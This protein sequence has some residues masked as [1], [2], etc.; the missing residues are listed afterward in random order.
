MKKSLLNIVVCNRCKQSFRVDILEGV[1]NEIREAILKCDRCSDIVLVFD[2][3]PRFVSINY[4]KFDRGFNEFQCKYQS[5]PELTHLPNE[6]GGDKYG[7]Q[8]LKNDTSKSFGFEWNYFENWG[9]IPDDAVS[10]EDKAFKYYGGLISNTENAFRNKCMLDEQDL[11]K[12]KIVLDAGCGNGRFTNQAAKYGAEVIGVDIGYGVKSAYKNL[13]ER[14]NV[15][16]IQG[17]LFNLPFR[18]KIFDSVFSNGVLMHTGD[19]YKAFSSIQRHIKNGGIFVSHLYHQRN[20]IFEI[21]DATIRFFTTKLS[22]GANIRFA[23]FM[24][25]QGIKLKKSGQL[26]KWFRFI[27][28][29]PTEHHMFDWYSAPI[30]THHTYPEV[31]QWYREHDFEILRTNEPVKRQTSFLNKPE[32]LTIKGRKR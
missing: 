8:K 25:S 7:L 32:S 4:L 31:K 2:G 9:W 22:I 24:A 29:L 28:I 16:I 13:R 27:Q 3:I 21:V 23:K 14:K 18:D 20:L 10:E 17:D 5:H 12:E 30:A 19:A 1:H 11:T 15:H 26:T 6:P